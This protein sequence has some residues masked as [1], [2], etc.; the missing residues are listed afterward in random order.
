MKQNQ[1]EFFI[2]ILLTFFLFKFFVPTLKIL[3]EIHTNVSIVFMSHPQFLL[4]LFL[5][6]VASVYMDQYL[7]N[8]I[9]NK[10]RMYENIAY[11]FNKNMYLYGLLFYV[12]DIF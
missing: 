4:L 9:H 1:K 12:R 2:S 11:M 8:Q 5:Y 6:I 7:L 3:L 10:L